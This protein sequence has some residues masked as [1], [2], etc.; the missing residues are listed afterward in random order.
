M[1]FVSVFQMN[2][3][4][5]DPEEDAMAIVTMQKIDN[6]MDMAAKLVAMQIN[7]EVDD[8]NKEKAEQDDY[9]DMGPGVPKPKTEGEEMD[10]REKFAQ[11]DIEYPKL[12]LII[13]KKGCLKPSDKEKLTEKPEEVIA[14]LDGTEGNEPCLQIR[15]N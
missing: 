5:F 1:L 3:K 8:Q 10:Q 13:C 4:F 6:K 2:Q 7:E 12:E 11:K 15:V 9:A 14:Y